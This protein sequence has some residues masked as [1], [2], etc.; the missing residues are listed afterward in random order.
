MVTNLLG[1]RTTFLH[2][3]SMVRYVAVAPRLH[4]AVAIAPCTMNL[5]RGCQL[6]WG[7]CPCIQLK[8]ELL[9]R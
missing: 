6:C 8:P 7:E 3:S 2:Q 9:V 1:E 5:V 4:Q